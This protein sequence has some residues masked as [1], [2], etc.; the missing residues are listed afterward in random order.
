MTAFLAVTARL[1]LRYGAGFLIAKGLL[2]PEA[3]PELANDVDLQAMIQVGLG[4]AMTAA[5][6]GWYA[7]ARRLGWAT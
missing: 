5:A 4:L 1:L 2:A 6:E 7:L 3:G